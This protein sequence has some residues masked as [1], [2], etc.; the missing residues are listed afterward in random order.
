V[1]AA[2]IVLLMPVLTRSK[3]QYLHIHDEENGWGSRLAA[4]IDQAIHH[5]GADRDVIS[6]AVTPLATA[7]NSGGSPTVGVVVTVVWRAPASEAT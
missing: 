1:I 6:A 5:L 7:Y 4:E 3:S 2:T